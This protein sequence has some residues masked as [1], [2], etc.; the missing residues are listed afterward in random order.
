ME[1]AI[2]LEAAAT[3]ESV[4][5]MHRLLPG[6]RLRVGSVYV[7]GAFGGQTAGVVHLREHPVPIDN[8]SS[9]LCAVEGTDYIASN[10]HTVVQENLD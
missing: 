6:N 7:R 4:E 3:E 10:E 5:G 2:V 9:E 8:T 1:E